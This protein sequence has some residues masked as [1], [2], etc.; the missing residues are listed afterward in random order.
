VRDRQEPNPCNSSDRQWQ[1][2]GAPRYVVCDRCS[3]EEGT[4]KPKRAGARHQKT[5]GEPWVQTPACEIGVRSQFPKK[6]SSSSLEHRAGAEAEAGPI[7]VVDS[8]VTAEGARRKLIERAQ[9]GF[10][11]YAN[12]VV[13][14]G[15][16]RD[17]ILESGEKYRPGLRVRVEPGVETLAREKRPAYWSEKSTADRGPVGLEHQL[18]SAPICGTPK[19]GHS[20]LRPLADFPEREK[21]YTNRQDR[22]RPESKRLRIRSRSLVHFALP[23]RCGFALMAAVLVSGGGLDREVG[24]YAKLSCWNWSRWPQFP[25]RFDWPVR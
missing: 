11:L 4:R 25:R 8:P 6:L 18:H 12:T 7:Q 3:R 16:M 9:H 14:W 15:L 24:R 1:T 13:T 2:G 19:S 23:P 21:T 10:E 17:V 22:S 20:R 5:P